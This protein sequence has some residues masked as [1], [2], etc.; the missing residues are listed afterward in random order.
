M[1]GIHTWCV[2]GVVVILAAGCGPLRRLGYGGFGR[3]SWQQPD[4]VVESLAL[5]PG[6]HVADLGA[7]GGYFT[8]RL[9]AAVGGSGRV[10]AID[11][12]PEMTSHLAEQSGEKGY[13]NVQPILAEFDDPLIPEGGV[14]L[15][16][17]CNTYHHLEAREE[18]FRGA[19]KYL[20]PGGRLAV[21]EF[22]GNGWL[23]RLF[24]HFTAPEEIRAEIEAAGYHRV[25]AFDFLE[26]QSFQVFERAELKRKAK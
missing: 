9:A 6:A 2:F 7:G 25:A 16:F 5:S 26:R 11:V 10:Y 13:P 22:N 12:D 15:I 24:P 23:Q 20:R 3:D 18:Y 14:D 8:W 19:A 1:R 4:R 21:I 17:T